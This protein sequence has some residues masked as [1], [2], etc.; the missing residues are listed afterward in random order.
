MKRLLVPTDFSEC[1]LY[2]AK[3][4]VSLARKT[5][6]QLHFF[7]KVFTHE[8][9]D[10]FSKEEQKKFLSEAQ[11]MEKVRVQ[12]DGFLG[13][14][15]IIGL[16]IVKEYSDGLTESQILKYSNKNEIDFIVMG[17]P[18][19]SGLDEWAIG[20]TTQKIVR[21]ATCPVIAVKY[22]PA[23]FEFKNIV[24]LSNYDIDAL[25]PFQKVCD[26]AKVFDSK[27]HLLN[28]DTPAY[29]TE[30]PFV[31]KKSM[32]GFQK[33]YK[34]E[35]QQHRIEAW[36]VEGGLKKFLKQNEVD[37][38]VIPSRKK[39]VLRHLFFNSLA[40]GIVNHLDIPVMTI[41]F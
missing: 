3:V 30:V 33:L 14:L 37:L 36:G 29:F 41:K 10:Y 38:V 35:I 31:I 28:I 12:Y 40:E 32:D 23:S 6:A 2:A 8:Y 22:V 24:F 13:Q 17:T 20:S 34:G 26:F 19:T 25:E 21:K 4:A 16:D 7:H 39:S 9:Y 15:D 18:G 27:I 5:G 1:A 11:I